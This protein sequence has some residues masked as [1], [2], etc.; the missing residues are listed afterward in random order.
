MVRQIPMVTGKQ[1]ELPPFQH[2]QASIFEIHGESFGYRP[3]G[4]DVLDLQ[5]EIIRVTGS[6]MLCHD[7]NLL[8]F[9]RVISSGVWHSIERSFC[10]VFSEAIHGLDL[11]YKTGRIDKL[12]HILLWL[13]QDAED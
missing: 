5:L 10:A 2:R 3:R 7:E 13:V 1:P 8:R 4:R 12:T 6:A 11:F 9:V